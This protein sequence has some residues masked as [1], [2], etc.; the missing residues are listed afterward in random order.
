MSR[1]RYAPRLIREIVGFALENKAYWLIPLVLVLLAA[2]MLVGVSQGLAP[3]IYT[4][5]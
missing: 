2:A 3:L 1:I 5:F 4:L